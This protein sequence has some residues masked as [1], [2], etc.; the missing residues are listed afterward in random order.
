[1]KYT[2]V[3]YY[4]DN[5]QIWVEHAEAD[6]TNGAVVAAVKH[7]EELNDRPNDISFREYVCIVSVF[8]GHLKDLSDAEFVSAAIDWPGLEVE[9]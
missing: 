2:V 8:E 7:L 9:E 1:M 5:G 3:G 6:D 4:E